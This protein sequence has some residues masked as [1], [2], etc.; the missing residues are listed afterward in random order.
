MIRLGSFF[1]YF[2]LS[3]CCFLTQHSSTHLSQCNVTIIIQSQF[4]IVE[5]T[6]FLLF[7]E[8]KS[9]NLTFQNDI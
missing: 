5:L 2:T 7:V 6:H 4:K 8:S 3:T 9:E 1:F